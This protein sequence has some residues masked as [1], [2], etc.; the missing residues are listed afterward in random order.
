MPSPPLP[1][2]LRVRLVRPSAWSGPLSLCAASVILL[3]SAVFVRAQSPAGA[4]AQLHQKNV[5]PFIAKYCLDCH[6]PDVQ[7][8]EIGFHDYRELAKVKADEKTWTRVL[9]MIETGVMPPDDSPQPKAAERKAIVRDLERILFNVDCDGPPNPGR[10]TIRRLNRAEYNN[11]VRDLVGITFKPADDFPSDDVGS[12]FDNIGDVL[13][14]PPLLMEKYLTAAERVAEQTIITDV[15]QFA[16]SQRQ[17]RRQLTSEGQASYDNDRRRWVI[18]STGSVGTKFEFAREGEYVLRVEARATRAGDE[19]ARLELKVGSRRIKVFDVDAVDSRGTY[20][21]KTRVAPG[22][23]L[24]S[25]HF[26]NDF[27]DP[28]A[29]DPERRDRNLIIEGFEV[30]G[31]V[32]LREEDYPD[33][34]RKLLTVRPDGKTSVL[35]A[36]RKN[37]FPLVGRAFR[38]KATEEE[39]AGYARLVDQA[40]KEGDSF[41][42][43]MQVAVT[44]VLVSPH[45]LFRVENDPPRSTPPAIRELDDFELATRMS[46]FL[47]S[48]MPDDALF[49]AAAA[50]QLRDPAVRQQQVR[51]M[52]TDPKCEALV[53]NFAMQ[54]L[55]LRM[56]D[57]FT[58]DPQ[59]YPQFSPELKA[60][61]RRETELF[62]LAIVREDR[63]LLDFLEG[64]FT[65]L[66]T[67]LAQHYGIAG[68][69][70][71][72]FERIAL[73]DNHRTG[74]L[75]HA[76]VLAIT[77]NPARTSPVKRGK[78]IMENILGSA[79]PDPP[80]DVP[81]LEATG[82]NQPGLSL[83]KQLEIHR[84]NAV[85]ASCHKTMDQLGFGLENF[86]AIGRWR[87]MDGKFAVDA[88]G[89]LPGGEKFTGPSELADV[90]AARKDEFVRCLAEKMLTFALGRGLISY[91]RCAVDQ[92]VEGVREKDYRFSALVVEIVESEPFRKRSGEGTTP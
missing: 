12:G 66:N 67:R 83:R 11:T 3:A 17:D 62:C 69:E 89:E 44:A 20:E 77:S 29:K 54:W 7:E 41:E 49:A 53:Q 76:S 56:L 13:T 6:G 60:D 64:R 22:K 27:Y 70:G 19:P 18:A 24:V 86:D 34:H 38:R 85:C 4:P 16:K 26:I 55:N 78:W 37:L 50:G 72:G 45:F 91:D 46:Y 35:E 1:V 40:V 28:D 59:A 61:M 48:S 87:T 15:K 47:W 74:V 82:K 21:V 25:A 10:V 65:Y 73:S 31:P 75:T 57:G 92:I 5:L 8:A 90:L 81:E 32:D 2:L 23:H 36:A 39:V 51:R 9:Q 63:S 43:A 58:P 84:S 80:P 42:Q 52:L 33:S 79:P 14:L 68:V 30:D 71:D 88:S